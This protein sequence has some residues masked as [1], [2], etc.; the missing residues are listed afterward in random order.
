M[1]LPCNLPGSSIVE[2][3]TEC[4]LSSPSTSMDVDTIYTP[5]GAR[6]RL[7]I[8]PP[9]TLKLAVT[10]FSMNGYSR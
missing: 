2:S 4:L 10:S 8:G 7:S 5:L 1:I 3:M 6:R 9:L